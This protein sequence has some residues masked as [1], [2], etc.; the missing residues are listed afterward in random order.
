MI[1]RPPI[2]SDPVE[3]NGLVVEYF[4]QCVGKA[5][6]PTKPGLALHLGYCSRQS[7][8]D[9]VNKNQDQ[10]ISYIIKRA[11]SMIE[12]SLCQLDSSMAIFQLKAYCGLKDKDDTP[13][14]N[15][16]KFVEAF[17]ALLD[18]LPQ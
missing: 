7:L 16:D 14:D 18:K 1:T 4:E 17:S 9:V 6:R 2:H 13:Q 5:K 12:D 10:E 3:L 8:W 15:G 11:D